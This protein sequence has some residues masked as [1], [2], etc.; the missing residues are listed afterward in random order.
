MGR[1]AKT[2][3]AHI[4]HWNAVT[5]QTWKYR[6]LRRRQAPLNAW[7]QIG[8]PSH[9]LRMARIAYEARKAPGGAYH[10]NIFH[11]AEHLTCMV[12]EAISRNETPAV[13]LWPYAV[14][15]WT[16]ALISISLPGTQI[17]ST[18]CGKEKV[19]AR[20]WTGQRR[21]CPCWQRVCPGASANSVF[22]PGRAG[23]AAHAIL[24]AAVH[25]SCDRMHPVGL[26]STGP[27]RVRVLLRPA[28][29]GRQ[30][31]DE[32]QLLAALRSAVG[33]SNLKVAVSDASAI[34]QPTNGSRA[35]AHTAFLCAQAMWYRDARFVVS[36][37]GAQ[38]TNAIFADAG[39]T[40]VDVQ[41][42]SHKPTSAAPQDYYA[43]LL[44]NTDVRYIALATTRPAAAPKLKGD[45]KAGGVIDPLIRENAE[46]CREDTRC[47]L[48][49]RDGGNI[50]VGKAGLQRL[51]QL[52]AHDNPNGRILGEAEGA[53]RMVD[54][55]GQI[56]LP[57]RQEGAPHETQTA[58]G[59]AAKAKN[60]GAE[61]E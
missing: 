9:V 7:R 43:A 3:K 26:S 10:H 17:V 57:R 40:I 42:Y 31:E 38:T 44:E 29:S 33:E 24:R 18:C 61:L 11:Q 30:L 60:P 36:V 58:S 47:R 49:Y 34:V 41:P 55:D 15:D 2:G 12:R 59:G 35:N 50:R 39:A 22:W 37:H 32:A 25:A 46:R 51:R 1:H 54:H 13:L 53:P 45:L 14:M 8:A 16:R 5:L 48:A 52:V 27:V 4:F 19:A 6:R 21:T 23:R 20:W 56:R 28:S